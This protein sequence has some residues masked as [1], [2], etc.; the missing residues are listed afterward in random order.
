VKRLVSPWFIA[1]HL[2]G[3]HLAVLWF[4]GEPEEASER[5][6]EHAQ[7]AAV[8]EATVEGEE[9]VA[10]EFAV[11]AERPGALDLSKIYPDGD[12]MMAEL[13]NQ[14][15]AELTTSPHL[16]QR[17]TRALNRAKV[18]FGA[19]VVVDVASG[20]ILAMADRYDEHH[21]VAPRLDGDGP[22]H[23]ALRAVAPAASTYKVITTVG[24]L[25]AGVSP[26][27]EYPFK[28][29]KR[30]IYE[31][32]LDA[33]GRGAPRSSMGNALARSNNGFFARMADAH[34]E[35]ETAQALARRFGFN[36]VLPFPLLTDAS[37]AQ[38]PRNR[39]ERARMS[40]GFWHTKLTPLHGALIAA[41]VAGDG[42]MPTPRLVRRIISPEGK[43]IEAPS[44]PPFTTAMTPQMAKQVRGMMARTVKRGTARRAFAKWPKSLRK[45]TVGG[46]T[47]SL[48]LREPYT[49]FT[50][51]IGFAPA[52]KPRVAI[53][54]M[55][56][57]GE[58]W[59]QKAS[60]VAREVLASH[61]EAEQART[62][63]S[64]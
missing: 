13:G 30:R 26:T 6:T 44:R 59:W 64:R 5:A 40:A 14:W 11:P 25:E 39:L 31:K 2:V 58:L 4:T 46:K 23:L 49:S 29:A 63:A 35:R 21:A 47:G 19:V 18:P 12:R 60:D 36:R 20:D 7:L 62:H 41:A 53:A 48:A 24:L 16:Q 17:A 52:D 50:W 38:I 34:I 56:G 33:P 57:N 42:T 43:A 9:A 61:F 55:V 37:T 15:S 27:R 28:P 8:S 10:Q 3:L 54:V 22:P 1:L 45:I 51:F 32:Q